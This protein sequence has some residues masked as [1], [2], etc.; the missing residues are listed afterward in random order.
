MLRAHPKHAKLIA[1]KI[2]LL[3]QNPEPLDASTLR[4]YPYL[5]VDVGEYRVIYEVDEEEIRILLIGK[6]NDDAVYK[7]LKRK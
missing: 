3:M 1:A 5:R 2:H 6:R 4:G 7:Q